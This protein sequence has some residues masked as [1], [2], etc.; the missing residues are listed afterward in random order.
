M[1]SSWTRAA[2]AL[3]VA[4]L[5][6]ACDRGHG[7]IESSQ[8]AVAPNEPGLSPGRHRAHALPLNNP[9]FVPAALADFMRPDDLVIAVVVRGGA[10]AYPWWIARNHHVINDTVVVPREE[11]DAARDGFWDRVTHVPRSAYFDPF[12]PLL[13]TVCEVCSGASAYV[14]VIESQPDRALVFAQCRS[15]GSPAGDYNAVGTFTICDGQTHSRWHPFTGLAGSGPLAGTRLQRLPVQIERWDQWQREHPDT[16]VAIAGAEM[17]RRAHSQV[18][19]GARPGMRGSHPSYERYLRDH[20]QDEDRRLAHNTLVLGVS[21]DGDA[22]AYTLEALHRRGG[23]VQGV[24]GGEPYVAVQRGRYRATAFSR[25][26]DGRVLD[27]EIASRDPYRLRDAAGSLWNDVGEAVDGP[28]RGSVL[29]ILDDTYVA[30]WADWV[31][32]HQ[33]SEII[34]Q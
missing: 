26:L 12:I 27:F 21:S 9:S 5:L 17:R 16:V 33:G 15:R 22:R 19:H 30:E 8:P 6:S 4:L 29:R 1:E 23:L 7:A 10:R 34:A 32:A 13:V 11:I 25:R 24:I 28:L 20:P 18:S 31:M 3:A 14:P 2:G